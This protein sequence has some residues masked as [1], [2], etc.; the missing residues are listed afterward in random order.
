MRRKVF[1]S[2]AVAGAVS[3]LVMGMGA[4]FAAAHEAP[5]RA[6]R[7]A[8]AGTAPASFANLIAR[9][10]PAVVSV[11]VV[12]KATASVADADDSDQDQL[13]AQ[14]PAEPARPGRVA[15]S[16][17]FISPNGYI[18][19]NN[20]VI[21]G[22]RTITVRMNDERNMTATLV[23][24]DPDTDL[25]V[26]KVAGGKHPSVNFEQGA[27][28]RVGDWVVA[29][30]NPFDLGGTATAGIVSALKRPNLSGSDYVDYLQIDAPI[31]RGNSGGPAFNVEGRVIGV[32][33][34][35]Y[36]PTGGS[37]GIA[38]DIPA[39]V[40]AKVVRQLIAHGAVVRGFV[41]AGVQDV[42]PAIAEAL[43]I[44]SNAGALVDDV[45][46]GG[47]SARAG[48]CSGD[49]VEAVDGRPITSA[50]EM[51]RAVALAQPGQIVRLAVDRDR[52]QLNLTVTAGRR[53]PESALEETDAAPADDAAPEDVAA[54]PLGLT[55]SPAPD[56]GLEIDKVDPSS[57]A[58]QKG[59]EAGDVIRQVGRRP[60]NSD[61]DLAAALAASNAA[62]HKAVLVQVE[63]RSR[64]FFVA[65]EPT[66]PADAAG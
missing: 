26:L 63:R 18:V 21:A 50:A 4:Q 51:T 6:A 59:L 19:T 12:Q 39:D 13:A 65:L 2:T 33:S 55:L 27:G 28:P 11:E 1:V 60:V 35:I 53:P 24:A 15:G 45:T 56:G 7:R 46:A 8:P 17:F 54:P 48:L 5:P 20:H 10:A 36:S 3:A 30:G 40:A 25:A 64:N 43:G 38:F 34:A 9:V 41:G 22:A 47:P 14:P 57:D 62:H 52:R 66:S 29:L 58:A 44:Q 31:N 42:T 16:G 32:N 23:G 61:A 49:I 37:V